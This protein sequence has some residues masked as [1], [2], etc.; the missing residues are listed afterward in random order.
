MIDRSSLT[1]MFGT[2]AA[3]LGVRLLTEANIA[4]T[5]KLE[6]A[7]QQPI[8]NG[9]RRA[10]LRD[11]PLTNEI[12]VK[13]N[14]PRVDCRPLVPR[15]ATLSNWTAYAVAFAYRH[16]TRMAV[17]GQRIGRVNR[18]QDAQEFLHDAQQ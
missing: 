5:L 1:G 17:P 10:M 3:Q 14:T 9:L 11:V 13:G 15:G 8:T 16:V 2:R 18:T 6:G 7:S 4:S 12:Q